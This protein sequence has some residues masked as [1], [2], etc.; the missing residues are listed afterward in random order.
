MHN[1]FLFAFWFILPLTAIE[2]LS[3]WRTV[4]FS[5]HAHPSLFR[6]WGGGGEE[7]TAK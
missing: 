1:L 5:L 6:C 4:R 2:A 3:R 7:G